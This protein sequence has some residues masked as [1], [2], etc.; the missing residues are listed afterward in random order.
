MR[1]RA[2]VKYSHQ[3]EVKCNE[4]PTNK[5]RKIA[6]ALICLPETEGLLIFVL[7]TYF[8]GIFLGHYKCM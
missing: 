6:E 3:V 5:R 4:T 2:V 7:L 1:I 8:M